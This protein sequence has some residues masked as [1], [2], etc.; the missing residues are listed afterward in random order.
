[1]RVVDAFEVVEPL[2]D[3]YLQL[4][5]AVAVAG[6]AEDALGLRASKR[7]DAICEEGEDDRDLEVRIRTLLQ[8]DYRVERLAEGGGVERCVLRNETSA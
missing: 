8:A 4:R 3:A 1:M 6:D 2:L 5:D 7:K